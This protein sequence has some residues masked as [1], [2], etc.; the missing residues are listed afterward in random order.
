MSF[1]AAHGGEQGGE[2]VGG[3]DSS[4]EW[5]DAEEASLVTATAKETELAS[6]E[7]AEGSGGE[8]SGPEKMEGLDKG[9]EQWG[10]EQAGRKARALLS[11]R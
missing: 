8:G 5:G 10:G 7:G 3:G 11:I 6:D 1:S 2:P 9:E 4:C